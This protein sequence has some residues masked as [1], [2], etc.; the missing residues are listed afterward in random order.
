MLNLCY[1]CGRLSHADK[2]CPL[3]IQ[4]KGT[5]NDEHKQFSSALKATP[6]K[7]STQ[8]I[9]Y[10]PGFYD[11]PGLYEGSSCTSGKNGD[12]VEEVIGAQ[13]APV[14]E[15][16]QMETEENAEDFNAVVTEQWISGLNAKLLSVDGL[17]VNENEKSSQA[18]N[19][20]VN[21]FPSEFKDE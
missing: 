11:K 13:V 3:W 5:L 7:P 10:V 8:K 14:E 4:S 17:V 15:N 20:L 21:N 9:I 18:L 1:W 12:N 16:I 6:Y 2:D 19:S